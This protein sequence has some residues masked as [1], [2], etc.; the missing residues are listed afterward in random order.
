MWDVT[1]GFQVLNLNEQLDFLERHRAQGSPVVLATV[2]E[3]GGSTYS[4]AGARMLLDGEG[5]FRGMLSGG[6]L[7]GDLA[8]RARVALESAS[9]QYASYDLAAIDDELWGMGVGCDGV[10]RVMLQPVSAAEDYAPASFILELQCGRDPVTV[11]TCIESTISSIPAGSAVACAGTTL[12][13]TRT[14]SSLAKLFE[15]ELQNAWPPPGTGRSFRIESGG[16]RM[17]VLA[18]SIPPVPRVIVMGAGPD[19]IPLVR[20]AANL[21]WRCTVC[22][23]RPAYVEGNDFASAAARH[24]VPAEALARGIDLSQFDMAVIMSHHLASDRAYLRQVAESGIPYIGLLGPPGRRERLLADMPGLR[25]GL[26]PRLHG[27]AG[28]DLGGR[29]PSAIALSIVAEMQLHLAG[30]YANSDGVRSSKAG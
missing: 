8:M 20:F 28:L 17:L 4:K 3:T 23:H 12:R 24:C 26:A 14:G 1:F 25:T 13:A 19:A 9:V 10:M 6:C 21:G 30:K 22:D 16:E 15:T 2:Y 11:L 29:G 27:P 18:D 5:R 7:E